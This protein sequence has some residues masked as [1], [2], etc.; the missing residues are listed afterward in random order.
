MPETDINLGPAQIQTIASAFG[1]GNV[2]AARHTGKVYALHTPRGVFAL[3]FY[4][5]GATPAH[6]HATQTVRFTLAE[7]GLPIA[8]PLHSSTGTTVVEENGLQGEIQPWIPHTDD[9]GSWPNLLIAAGVLRHLHTVLAT[10][11]VQVDQR[12]DPWRPPEHLAA[13]LGADMPVLHTLAQ[14]R[15]I[16]ISPYL[17]RAIVIL[18]TLHTRIILDQCPRQLTHGDFQGSNLLFHE[19]SLRGII[20]FERLEYRPRLYDLA[21]PLVFW[22]WFG[23]AGGA[24]TERDWQYARACCAAYAQAA[25]EPITTDDWATLPLLMAYIPARGIAEAAGED[26][27]LE[28]ILAFGIALEFAEWLVQ[29]SGRAL[30]RLR[31]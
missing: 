12:D 22:R 19:S 17:H 6:I 24:Y 10:C 23:T 29:Y 25:S 7:A 30:E 18:E 5:A 27:P 31:G 1:L 28:E 16:D 14:Q 26:A 2:S 13:R 21:W 8:V 20:D 15:G 3:R 9:G 11:T 4:N